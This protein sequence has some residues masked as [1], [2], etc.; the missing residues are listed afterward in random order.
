MN[1]AKVKDKQEIQKVGRYFPKTKIKES[2]HVNNSLIKITI[3]VSKKQSI[4]T[5]S[6]EDRGRRMLTLKDMQE[7]DNQ[8]LDSDVTNIFDQIF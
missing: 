5:T 7:M 4:N 1:P 3:K 6:F 2:M 8:F